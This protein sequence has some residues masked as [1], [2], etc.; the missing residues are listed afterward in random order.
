[1]IDKRDNAVRH[2][3]RS[4]NA[5]VDGLL[6]YLVRSLF[7]VS[8][9]SQTLHWF[10]LQR[11][12]QTLLSAWPNARLQCRAPLCAAQQTVASR[13]VRVPAV[14]AITVT[15]LLPITTMLN[16]AMSNEP[17]PIVTPKAQ[18]ALD[19]AAEQ[20]PG[21]AQ[22]GRA[23]MLRGGYAGCGIPRSV[24]D[25]SLGES[26]PPNDLPTLADRTPESTGLP[27]FLSDVADPFGERVISNN[28]LLCHGAPLFGD[29]VE[30]LGNE[31]LDFTEDPSRATERAGLL[32][33]NAAEEQS[34]AYF[35]DRIA[36]VAPYMIA[37]TVGANIAN[38]LTF[39]LMAHRD[40]ET[41]AWSE[42]PFI[43]PPE[44]YPLP[45]S[46]PPWWRLKYKQGMFYQGQGQ[47]DH[48]RIMM[49][50]AILCA[51]DKTDVITADEMAPHLRQYIQELQP[52]VY[53]FAIDRPLADTGRD[54]FNA[55]C[56]RCHGRY[57][58]AAYYPDLVVPV[59]VVGTDPA[60]AVQAAR[61]YQR[62]NEW[63]DDSFFGTDTTIVAIAGYSAPP[64]DGVWATAPFL[65]NG[66]VP[67]IALMLNS[68]ARPDYW[69][70]P[71]ERDS[72]AAFYDQQAL[73]WQFD[74]LSQGK[75]DNNLYRDNAV[76]YDTTQRG[77]GNDGH[78]FGD[79][80][81]ESAR[82]AVLEYLKTL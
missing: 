15:V 82:R 33:S 52:P 50:A 36:T 32:V 11:L 17:A 21:D 30:G 65:H 81:S 25:Q 46:V 2:L 59:E 49:T 27:Y 51:Q 37:S 67:S 28:C 73:G 39:A 44:T 18:L 69:R 10:L 14:L 22:T 76:I 48:A 23:W 60:L 64:L 78:T 62:F 61:D 16:P 34:W 26:A 53:P 5:V 20:R 45:V 63:Y 58:D 38:N 35:A 9:W 40:A 70:Y 79:H 42:T 41:L 29:V 4:V 24:F 13:F 74:P 66:S 54:I 77:Y 1:M 80:L 75:N 31:F 57:D 72:T 12:L 6:R 56:S 8:R 3:S 7:K 43:D 47:G 55:T 68:Q 71:P 19:R